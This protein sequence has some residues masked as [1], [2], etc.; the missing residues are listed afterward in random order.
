MIVRPL[1]VSD[2]KKI[3]NIYKKCARQQQQH[4]YHYTPLPDRKKNESS[5]FSATLRTPPTPSRGFGPR[6][7]FR[8]WPIDPPSID[9]CCRI[10]QETPKSSKVCCWPGGSYC[11]L[12]EW[13]RNL[14]ELEVSICFTPLLKKYD[15][16]VCAC[17]CHTTTR[18]VVVIKVLYNSSQHHSSSFVC[19]LSSHGA[20]REN[21]AFFY[22]VCR[23]VV[24][25]G[26]RRVKP[27]VILLL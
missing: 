12:R 8:F 13:A 17:A 22:L 16:R 24:R 15:V 27:T 19:L 3:K 10:S 2:L 1:V 14:R 9:R 7:R 21:G 23:G 26:I 5:F 25:G 18:S 4:T 20:A 11:E 6:F